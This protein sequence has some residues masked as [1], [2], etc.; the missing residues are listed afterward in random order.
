[1]P[2]PPS[3][4]APLAIRVFT[5]LALISVAFRLLSLSGVMFLFGF[6]SLFTWL[7]I[8]IL[9]SLVGTVLLLIMAIGLRRMKKWAMYVLIAST[10][11]LIVIPFIDY[12]GPIQ[13]LGELN[14]DGLLQIAFTIYV[15]VI[16][17]QFV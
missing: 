10:L 7:G 2:K 5:L 3:L 13:V 16:R 1:M 14:F 4:P 11:I 6:K 8:P 17:R 15:L 9:L 12:I